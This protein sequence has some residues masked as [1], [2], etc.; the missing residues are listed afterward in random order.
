MV[1]NALKITQLK[2]YEKIFLRLA[3]SRVVIILISGFYRKV[4]R[5][6]P[7]IVREINRHNFNKI[8][9]NYRD[10]PCCSR[11]ASLCHVFKSCIMHSKLCIIFIV[12][13]KT[14]AF[15]TVSELFCS[16]LRERVAII[17]QAPPL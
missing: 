3:C 9:F 8:K 1:F 12:F 2:Y 4:P 17:L 14:L 11:G 16:I 5:K 7:H 10:A 15:E 6:P 13:M